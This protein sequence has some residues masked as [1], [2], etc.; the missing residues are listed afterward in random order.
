[1]GESVK[2]KSADQKP[3]E[4]GKPNEWLGSRRSLK[5]TSRTVIPSPLKSPQVFIT[6]SPTQCNTIQN[7]FSFNKLQWKNGQ[8][9]NGSSGR[10]V[11]LLQ[12]AKSR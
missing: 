1:M 2:K 10:F 5:L 7:K 12:A 3:N 4:D 11:Q 8:W 6:H 9:I